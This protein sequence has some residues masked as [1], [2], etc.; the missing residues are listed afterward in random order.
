MSDATTSEPAAGEPQPVSSQSQKFPCSQCGAQLDYDPSQKTLTCPYC[1]HVQEIQAVAAAVEEHDLFA[2]LSDQHKAH[3]YGTEVKSVHC[4]SCG[5]TFNVDPQI[6]STVCPFCGSN[7]I[8]EQA[9]DPTLIQPESLIPFEIDKSKA[10][11]LFRKWL[12][13]GWFRPGDLTRLAG[14]E[15]ISGMYIPYWTFDAQAD[16]RWWAEAGYY[17]YEEELRWVTEDGKRVQRRERV[18]KTRWEPASGSHSNF[19]DDV[20]I[21]GSKGVNENIVKKLSTFD[22]KKLVPYQ[23]QYLS[24]W[25]AES[26]RVTLA[27]AWKIGQKNIEDGE[28]D[29]CDSLVPGDT[30]RN[31]RVDTKLSAITFKH[32]LLPI[33]LA[34]YRYQGK[35]FQFMVNGQTGEVEGEAPISWIKVAIAVIIALV[36]LACICMALNLLGGGKGA[37]GSE[38]FIFQALGIC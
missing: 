6:T 19:Y 22:T 3:G 32:A 21:C 11:T 1:G 15:Q 34:S 10:M 12:G 17:Y 2:A 16:S 25:A 33:W 38:T 28:R 24:G 20:L 9:L 13:S 27:D 8:L 37:G 5:A 14:A 4:K 7:Q 23:P 30:H 36:I 35:V 18:Q 26:Y 31:L 29:A